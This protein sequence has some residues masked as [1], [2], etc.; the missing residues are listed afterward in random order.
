MAEQ[1]TQ[2]GIDLRAQGRRRIERIDAAYKAEKRFFD[3]AQRAEEIYANEPGNR[4]NAADG[5]AW[6]SSYDFNILFS[7][8]ETIV[9][10]IINSPPVPDIRRRFNDS[11]PAAKEVSDI[12]ERAIRVQ[13][14]DS[15]LQTEMERM[16]QD[17]FLGGRGLVRLRYRSEETN[18]EDYALDEKALDEATD[19]T[20]RDE[21]DDDADL[22]VE[23]EVYGE[24][25][26]FEAVSW[27]DFRRGPAKRWEDVPWMAF[28]HAIP[29]D[30]IESFAD[31]A[32]YSS[33]DLA[34]DR[35]GEDRETDVIMWEYWNKKTRDVWF[36]EEQTGKVLKK[37]EDPLGLSN[38]FPIC[39]PVQPIEINGR[40]MPVTPFAI[41]AKLAD[42]VDIVSLRIRL[43]TKAM[44]VKA[45]YGGN[46]VDITSIVEGDDSDLLPV[47]EPEMWAQQGGLNNM[48]SWWP[49][50]KFAAALRELYIARDQAKQAIYEI[51]GISDI[52]RGASRTQET[53]TAQQI[54]TQWGS[55]RIQKMQ[56]MMERGA[57]DLFVMMCE[58]IPSKFSAQTLQTMTGIQLIPTEQDMTPIQPQM[59]QPTGNPEQDQQAQQQAMMEAQQAEQARMEKLQKLASV[60]ALLQDNI[61]KS[62]R[63]DVETDSTIRADLTRQKQEVAEFLQGAAAFWQGIVPAVQAGIMSM[64]MAAQ[65]FSA[66][67]RMFNLGKDVEDAL[68]K[69]VSDAREQ[70]KQPK[71][72][73]PEQLK[74]QADQQKMQMEGQIKQ[75]EAQ[76][77][78]AEAA[79]QMQAIQA[80]SQADI[81]KVQADV[82]AKELDAQLKVNEQAMKS[83]ADAQS[84]QLEMQ[85]GMLELR[86]IEAEIEKIKVGTAGAIIQTQQKS[87]LAERQQS[88]KESQA[89]EP[90]K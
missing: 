16:A 50:D 45:L 43:L 87:E 73:S 30:D 29:R 39:T 63:I 77:R 40:L 80:K 25:I 32:L 47:S 54:K 37:V 89:Q 1:T 23:S 75:Q 41:Y 62:Y 82:R 49:V 5:V 6:Q 24:R 31:N 67:S 22:P 14:D 83:Q 69:M 33:Q 28:R 70:A 2:S 27:R 59:P 19:G 88:F 20:E 78:Q 3:T 7:N 79:A 90:K 18:K 8:V 9:P 46:P 53:A 57:R 86:K 68:D 48:L 66:N 36:I 71:P 58:I 4:S 81:T 11:D 74:A 61:Q 76:T 55:L 21:D 38:F 51:T 84:H 17:G 15:R 65:I 34:E 42:E 26:C 10:A 64:D 60:N 12:L 56:R 52:V 35:L 85:K 72:P 13:I 44:K